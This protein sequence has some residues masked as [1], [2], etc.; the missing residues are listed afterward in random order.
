VAGDA[1]AE[2]TAA[3]A[4]AVTAD[5]DATPKAVSAVADGK[6]DDADAATPVQPHAG[7]GDAAAPPGSENLSRTSPPLAMDSV[8][9]SAEFAEPDQEA[10]TPEG[11]PSAAEGEAA[12][13]PQLGSDRPKTPVVD[14]IALV[15][16]EGKAAAVAA[17]SPDT[18]TET[19][20]E[21]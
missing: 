20:T 8:D 7:D 19:E 6:A 15:A 11:P 9:L 1:D 16:A 10:T 4:G 18:K 12:A 17:A 2:A 14:G 13:E 5:T 21:T 3:T